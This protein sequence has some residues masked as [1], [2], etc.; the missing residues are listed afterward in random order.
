MPIIQLAKLDIE[1]GKPFFKDI[2]PNFVFPTFLGWW[3]I[4]KRF[5]E[6]DCIDVISQV[7]LFDRDIVDNVLPNI[8]KY[9]LHNV[10]ARTTMFPCFEVIN[11][12][13]VLRT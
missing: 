6:E 10:G 2:E 5:E 13:I 8:K 11:W 12:I 9:H 4:Y 1:P 7:S 3:E